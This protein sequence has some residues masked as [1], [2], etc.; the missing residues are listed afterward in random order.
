MPKSVFSEAYGI[1]LQNLVALRKG[2]GVSQVE[3]ARRLGKE[4]PFVSRIERGERRIDVVE[5]WAIAKALGVEPGV[6][7]DEVT[8]RFPDDVAI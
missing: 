4:Q 2:R 7:F 6:A 3:L 1:M 5:F 8:K